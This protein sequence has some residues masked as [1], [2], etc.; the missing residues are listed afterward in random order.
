[1]PQRANIGEQ[2]PEKAKEDVY[3]LFY[4]YERYKKTAHI[5]DALSF[6]CVERL[7]KSILSYLAN[8]VLFSK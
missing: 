4:Q 3:S 7:E 2:V 5:Y 8:D 1:M 6:L